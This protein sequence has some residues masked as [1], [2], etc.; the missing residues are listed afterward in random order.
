MPDPRR[1]SPSCPETAVNSSRVA[2]LA[3]A[4]F[5]TAC[6]EG[7]KND[8]QPAKQLPPRPELI[9]NALPVPDHCDSAGHC[10]LPLTGNAD[11]LSLC[12]SNAPKLYWNQG[13]KDYLLACECECS[14]HDN[15]GWLVDA[16][17]GRV[18][19]VDLGKPAVVQDLINIDVVTDILASHPF[20]E[21]LDSNSLRSAEFVSLVK[22]P[23]GN[24]NVPYCF[25]PRVFITTG[26][27][28]VIKDNGSR[29]SEDDDEVFLSTSEDVAAK[30]L[31]LT[32][33]Q[34][35]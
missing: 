7:M 5:L 12:E 24:D 13:R 27:N 26:E 19:G 10:T 35:R 18:Q 8:M 22:Y 33:Q 32:R 9:A 15:T 6:S 2:V 17:A 21:A 25:S 29:I 14:S 23:T 4:A 30:V 34:A 3:L 11:A 16:S 28:I 1:S 31:T 20:C